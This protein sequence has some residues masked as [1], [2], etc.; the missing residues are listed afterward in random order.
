MKSL[1]ILLAVGIL[2]NFIKAGDLL[3]RSY[4]KKKLQDW[5]ETLTLRIDGLRPLNWIAA[6]TRPRPALYWSIFAALFAI[7]APAEALGG[8]LAFLLDLII[9]SV[10]TLLRAQNVHQSLTVAMIAGS[11]LSIPASVLT[12]RKLCPRLILWLVGG[13]RFWPFLGRL[14]IFYALSVAWLAGFWGLA[15]L[16]RNTRPLAVVTAFVL[17]FALSIY[18][19]NVTGWLIVTLYVFLRPIS[20]LVKGIGGICWRIVEY[21]QGVFGGLLLIATVALGFAKIL[22]DRK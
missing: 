19:L 9:N 14:I 21:S 17:P 6:L 3:L 20:W 4:Q 22:L 13:A 2:A 5:F 8:A 18:F 12:V 1:D 15:F 16:T 7:L 11:L 10:L